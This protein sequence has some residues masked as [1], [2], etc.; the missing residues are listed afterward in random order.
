MKKNKDSNRYWMIPLII[1]LVIIVFI[2]GIIVGA[3]LTEFNTVQMS[4]DFYLSP[5]VAGQIKITSSNSA[6]KT[7]NEQ[8]SSNPTPAATGT[9]SPKATDKPQIGVDI[10]GEGGLLTD[11]LILFKAEYANAD[12]DIT[13]KSLTGDDVIAPGTEN[14][15]RLRVVNTGNVAIDYSIDIASLFSHSDTGYASPIEVRLIDA[16]GRYLIGN[17]DTWVRIDELSTVRDAGTLG[18]NSYTYYT[19]QWRWP[20]ERGENSEEIQDNDMIDT[21]IANLLVEANVEIGIEMTV[22]AELSTNPDNP[23]GIPNPG[24]GDSYSFIIWIFVAALA[25][26]L[27]L[28]LPFIKRKREDEDYDAEEVVG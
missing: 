19:I 23:G 16:D 12:G 26:V 8:D 21:F 24:T 7:N 15:Y 1:I 27:L 14:Q 10:I 2:S 25:L 3:R 13:V 22:Y 20:F 18:R 9:I 5:N 4:K 6:N 11:N 17:S 28:I